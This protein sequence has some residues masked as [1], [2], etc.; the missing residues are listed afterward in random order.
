MAHRSD[1]RLRVL[2][3]LRLK[4]FADAA[5]V[6][7]SAGLDPAAASARLD[8][9]QAEGMVTF[10]TGRR[11]GWALTTAGREE[12]RRRVASDL[13]AARCRDAVHDAYEAFLRL[14]A[15]LLAA[16]TAWQLREIDHRQVANDHSD[17]AYDGAVLSRLQR[18]DESVRTPCAA[19]AA[20]M[21]RFSCY[22]PRLDEARARVEEGEAEWFTRP[23]LDSYHSV[24]F[25]LHED[26]LTTLGLERAT[27]SERLLTGT[28]P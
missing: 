7:V 24:W 21:E 22:R 18:V 23:D 17:P 28:E 27:E 15:E 8:H 25:E 19:L 13:E 11:P 5:T 9:L 2:H 14:N 26:L 1:P 10:R 16:C 12:H 6:G 3:A 4:G 20:C